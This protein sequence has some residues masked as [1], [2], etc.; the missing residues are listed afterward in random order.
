VVDRLA[1]AGSDGAAGRRPAG[2]VPGP[3]I[4]PFEIAPHH[5]FACGTLNANGLRMLIHVE[6]GRAWSEGALDRRFEG[7]EGIAHG[8]ILCTILD[9]VMAWALVGAENWGLT[10][11]L[12]V[13][14][15]RP[16]EVGRAFRADG[17][18]TRSRR[19]LVDT[20]GRIV[21]VE[22]GTE[23]ATAEGIYV[24]ASRQR[25]DELRARYGFRYT[26]LSAAAQP[27]TP[28]MVAGAARS[29]EPRGQDG[30]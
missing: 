7:W 12:A 17:W 6:A 18:I 29:R 1:A 14:F 26:G 30:S 9:E 22:T 5:C 20:A 4:A 2:A 21:D 3:G 11:R 10:A 24:A 27:E 8:G 15:R 25:R 23:L 19:R 28:E 16:V 13:D